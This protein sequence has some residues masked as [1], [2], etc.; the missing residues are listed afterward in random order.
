MGQGL[1]IFSHEI[2]PLNLPPRFDCP[3]YLSK[4]IHLN[5]NRPEQKQLFRLLK[6][7]LT[8]LGMDGRE[9]FDCGT[10]CFSILFS[11]VTYCSVRR[12]CTHEQ[13]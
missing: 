10:T 8:G 7:K 13:A 2:T 6:V 4:Q 11:Y 1:V 9:V 5:L 12:Q 3:P